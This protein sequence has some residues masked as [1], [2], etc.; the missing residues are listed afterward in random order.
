MYF[1]DHSIIMQMQWDSH[2]IE[3]GRSWNVK[4]KYSY[5]RLNIEFKE[6]MRKVESFSMM[7]TRALS[8][9][10]SLKRQIWL[11]FVFSA[12]GSKNLVTVWEKYLRWI[13]FFQKMVWLVLVGLGVT[14]LELTHLFPML[15]FTTPW[16]HHKTLQFSDVF[17]SSWG[18][19]SVYW[20]Q[21]D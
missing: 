1:T 15:P 13:E 21:M 3:F 10:W 5:Q 8:E 16:K 9:L 14:V 6:W 19:E 4:M 2:K 17:R 12:D 11:I 20:E 7:F 18:R